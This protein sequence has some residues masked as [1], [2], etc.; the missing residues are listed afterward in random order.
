MRWRICCGVCSLLYW[1]T[2]CWTL[3]RRI[4][5]PRHETGPLT[6]WDGRS[7]GQRVC[8]TIVSDHNA[9]QPPRNQNHGIHG[10]HGKKPGSRFCGRARSVEA[11]SVIRL[12]PSSFPCI[13]CVPW[14]ISASPWKVQ[15][16]RPWSKSNLHR[17][18][19]RTHM[20]SEVAS[21]LRKPP[22]GMSYFGGFIESRSASATQLKDDIWRHRTLP[23]SHM[24]HPM[25]P[26]GITPTDPPHRRQQA[27]SLGQ[28]TNCAAHSALFSELGARNANA[29]WHEQTP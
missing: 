2:I 18:T 5:S 16:L 29:P 6:G 9:T 17:R 26:N 7:D 13:P 22:S 19:G 23:G 24:V 12:P 25:W 11:D 28:F 10:I 8:V 3:Q 4:G 20:G 14:F 1:T 27:L 15:R 21:V